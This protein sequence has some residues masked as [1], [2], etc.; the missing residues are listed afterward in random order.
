V[1][2]RKN[3]TRARTHARI[4]L[5]FLFFIEI[6]S[7]HMGEVAASAAAVSSST[8]VKEDEERYVQVGSR[9]FRVKPA[10]GLTPRARHHYLDACFLCMKSISRDSDIFMYRYALTNKLSRSILLLQLILFLTGRS[11]GILGGDTPMN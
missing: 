4:T 7:I 6:L 1:S 3:N 9:F 5:L 10:G 8:P 11:P 2:R